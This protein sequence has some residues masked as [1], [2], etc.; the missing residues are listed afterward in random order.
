MD[1]R[2]ILRREGHVAWLIFN[3]PDRLNAMTIA[4]WQLMGRQLAKLSEDR[5]VRCLVL[6]GEGRA[7]LAGHDVAEIR[8]HNELIAAGKLAPAQLR[9]WQKALQNMS[10]PGLILMW[11]VIASSSRNNPRKS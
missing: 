5:S 4:T 10:F 2:I 1:D 3:R 8:E 9:E 7:F 11:S 6:A